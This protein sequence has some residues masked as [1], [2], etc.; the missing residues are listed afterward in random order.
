MRNNANKDSD[1][2]NNSRSF[3]VLFYLSSY[4]NYFLVIF[5]GLS[6]SHTRQLFSVC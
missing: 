1:N 2:N 5:G 3:F 4:V 6:Q